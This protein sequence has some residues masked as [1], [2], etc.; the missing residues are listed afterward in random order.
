[1]ENMT[2]TIMKSKI[3]NHIDELTNGM[4][5]TMG[6]SNNEILY[7]NF[8]EVVIEDGVKPEWFYAVFKGTNSFSELNAIIQYTSQDSLFK[9]ISELM[10]GIAIV[11]MKH[12]N[13]L[14]DFILALGGNVEMAYETTYVSYGDSEKNA[15]ELAI[16]AEKETICEYE[17]IKN[18]ILNISQS[19]TTEIAL[20]FLSKLI[21]D[22]E[23][24]I[25]LFND[26]LK[27][28]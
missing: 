7:P 1:M 17:N 21:A 4:V 12:L 23:K 2:Y 26:K 18:K 19:K 14:S 13:K 5:N 6:Y 28:L 15:I 27:T 25:Q 3:T 11:E 16:K 8:D 9:N 10:L 20:Q 22:E 24:H